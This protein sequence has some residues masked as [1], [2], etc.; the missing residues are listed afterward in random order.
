MAVSSVIVA[1]MLKI[2]PEKA[3]LAVIISTLL[4]MIY[5]PLVLTIIK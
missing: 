5:I 2:K 3:A 1:N 4:A